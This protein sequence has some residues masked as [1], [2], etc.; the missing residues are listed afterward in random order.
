MQGKVSEIKPTIVRIKLPEGRTN[1]QIQKIQP[2]K[3]NKIGSDA[4]RIDAPRQIQNTYMQEKNGISGEVGRQITYSIQ[5]GAYLILKNAQDRISELKEKGYA[6]KVV[7]F[8]DSENRILHTVR[9]G[10]YN[11]IKL[12]Q[13]DAKILKERD[14]IEAVVLPSDKF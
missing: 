5:V 8:E 9:I 6:A 7:N 1:T 2:P 3:V 4:D 12:A 14:E 13:E 10:N 11:S